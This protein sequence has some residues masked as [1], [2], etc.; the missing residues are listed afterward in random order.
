MRLE[1]YEHIQHICSKQSEVQLNDL[2][3]E[4]KACQV[5]VKVWGAILEG[6]GRARFSVLLGRLG[7]HVEPHV[8]WKKRFLSGRKENP[9]RIKASR[10]GFGH[11]WVIEDD[12]RSVHVASPRV[13]EHI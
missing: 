11:S 3:D 9:D 4:I 10:T 6:Y 5:S 12:V 8:P 2:T 13:G 7:F 1:R